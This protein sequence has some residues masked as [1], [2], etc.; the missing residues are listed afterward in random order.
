MFSF[1]IALLIAYELAAAFFITAFINVI[2][3]PHHGVAAAIKLSIR[4]KI[5]QRHCLKHKKLEPK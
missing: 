2:L 4:K 1:L 3:L 5:V